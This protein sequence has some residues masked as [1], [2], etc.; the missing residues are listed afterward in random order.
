MLESKA[1]QAEF[2]IKVQFL[3]EQRQF[4][5]LYKL[6]SK[7]MDF[8]L[9]TFTLRLLSFSGKY[10]YRNPSYWVQHKD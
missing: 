1:K 3:D 9:S 10:F 6:Q 4:N 8:S 2:R 7:P 5:H